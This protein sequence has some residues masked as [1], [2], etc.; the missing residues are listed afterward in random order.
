MKQIFTEENACKYLLDSMRTTKSVDI[1]FGRKKWLFLS[2]FYLTLMIDVKYSPK[3]G[4]SWDR[5][6]DNEGRYV[7]PIED[8]SSY[9][10]DSRSLPQVE[11]PNEYHRYTVTRDFSELPDAIRN[12]PDGR[13]K[14]DVWDVLN[15]YYKGDVSKLITYKGPI[16]PAFN[17]TATN[18]VQVEVPL[19]MEL[20]NKMGF[21]T[22]KEPIAPAFDTTGQF[23]L[24][25]ASMC[26]LIG[27]SGKCICLNRAEEV[28]D[29][30]L[31][32]K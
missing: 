27:Q 23:V 24:L 30:C 19:S 15:E 26:F 21:L 32:Q 14:S 11:N 29:L 1:K 16:A 18:A 22:Y 25:Y 28:H 20:L 31:L 9:P 3:V 12:L 13:L 5:F 7:S 2:I 8:G 4:D 6:G 17:T 10:F